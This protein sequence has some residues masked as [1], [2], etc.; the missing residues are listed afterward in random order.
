MMFGPKYLVFPFRWFSYL[1]TVFNISLGRYYW[2]FSDFPVDLEY[3]A[4][5]RGPMIYALM[6]SLINL[7]S[8]TMNR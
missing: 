6:L 1:I 2:D 7:T 8:G 3:I 5:L 4:A